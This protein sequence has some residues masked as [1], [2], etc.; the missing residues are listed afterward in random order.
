MMA[1]QY[2]SADSESAFDKAGKAAAAI[3][4]ELKES[5]EVLGPFKAVIAK[6][7]DIYRVVVYIRSKDEENLSRAKDLAEKLQDENRESGKKEVTLQTD[8][9]PVN[10]L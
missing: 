8:L 10:S 5:A 3:R 2:Y 4:E 1:L 7:R 9:D 6:I